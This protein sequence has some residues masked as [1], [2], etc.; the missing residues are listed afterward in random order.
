VDSSLETREEQALLV[1]CVPCRRLSVLY[2]RAES[3]MVQTTTVCVAP[4]TITT[5][6]ETSTLKCGKQERL[7]AAGIVTSIMRPLSKVASLVFS[8][9]IAECIATV[10]H[11]HFEDGLRRFTSLSNSVIRAAGLL[12]A[13]E[14]HSRV[15]CRDP[16][17]R[18]RSWRRMPLKVDVLTYQHCP[19]VLQRRTWCLSLCLPGLRIRTLWPDDFMLSLLLC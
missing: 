10:D 4:G 9:Q 12:T 1:A 13:C 8:L 19:I 14:P 15:F 3:A 16:R 17:H 6:H 7:F 5:S 18:Q 11:V 2:N